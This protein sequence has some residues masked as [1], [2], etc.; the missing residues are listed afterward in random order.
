MFNK[1]LTIAYVLA[2]ITTA[3][4]YANM[5]R[6]QYVTEGLVSYWSFDKADIEG[7]TV[8][9]I[10]GE[11]DGTIKGDTQIVEG[12]IGEALYFDGKRDYVDFGSDISLKMEDAFTIA[13]WVK[14]TDKT[15]FETFLSHS[16]DADSWAYE[17]GV[18]CTEPNKWSLRINRNENILKVA[19][20]GDAG[21]WL[22]V[23]YTYD[24]NATSDQMKLYENRNLLGTETCTEEIT[25]HGKLMTN[26]EKDEGWLKSSIDELLI[27]NRALSANE[28]QKNFDAYAVA[29]PTKKLAF[30]WG[31]IKASR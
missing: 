30:T 13:L 20:V 16:G 7:K 5:A 2:V 24:R 6:A 18:D 9:D 11:N 29:S 14:R 19:M 21:T 3:F 10:W 27:Y 1:I 28:V 22:H 23:V 15:T 8:K 31:E 4:M 17:V 25:N 12:K 26:R